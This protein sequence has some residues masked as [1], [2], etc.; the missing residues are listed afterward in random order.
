METEKKHSYG[1]QFWTSINLFWVDV[2][3][4][5]YVETLLFK[6]YMFN[7]DNN[8]MNFFYFIQKC[9]GIKELF[10]NFVKSQ[11]YFFP[12]PGLEYPIN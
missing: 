8:G 2:G 10:F 4:N 6:V 1:D 9:Y 11:K 5:W 7:H 12:F 3:P